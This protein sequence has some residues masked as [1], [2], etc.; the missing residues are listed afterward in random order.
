MV[1]LS[2][3]LW[4]IKKFPVIYIVLIV[5]SGALLVYFFQNFKVSDEGSQAKPDDNQ[6]SILGAS[7]SEV[8]F[9]APS[10]PGITANS[11]TQIAG[12]Q[13]PTLKPSP[14]STPKPTATATPTPTPEPES[15]TPTP[16]APPPPNP[17]PP[18]DPPPPPA[19]GSGTP[20]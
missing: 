8:P 5:L 19:S 11:Q 17:P 14:T 1:Y 9:A 16:T 12:P 6:L 20:N 18:A 2:V 13:A 3:M 7:A 4:K 10:D 15:P